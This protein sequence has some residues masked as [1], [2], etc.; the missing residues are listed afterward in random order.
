MLASKHQRRGRRGRRNAEPETDSQS[1]KTE[2]PAAAPVVAADDAAAPM[3]APPASDAAH[4]S[5]S[6]A[7]AQPQPPPPPQPQAGETAAATMKKADSAEPDVAGGEAGDQPA[8]QPVAAAAGS[9]QAEGTE[10]KQ[11]CLFND[12]P[13]P[14]FTSHG[15]S[16]T[17]QF[18]S[19]NQPPLACV[20]F[21]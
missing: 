15:A 18:L 7:S 9:S 4:V 17:S 12:A 1:C 19:C 10:S 14:P 21:R 6:S 13:C 8:E 20:V 2:P 11:S 3:D 16:I 5:D